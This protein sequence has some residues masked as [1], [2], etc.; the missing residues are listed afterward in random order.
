[1]T[2]RQQTFETLNYEARE[3]IAK[4]HPATMVQHRIE[5]IDQ[6]L[7]NLENTLRHQDREIA[8]ANLNKHNA[9]RRRGELKAER[10]RM[11][12]AL[13]ALQ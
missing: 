11:V 10:H 1:M 4:S 3:Y 12:V 5:A 9:I 6:K 2:D 8:K 13:E 7:A